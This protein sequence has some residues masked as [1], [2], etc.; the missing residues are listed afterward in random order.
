MTLYTKNLKGTGGKKRRKK[1][2][3]SECSG[4]YHWNVKLEQQVFYL[5]DGNWR[6]VWFSFCPCWCAIHIFT[7]RPHTNHRVPVKRYLAIGW[8]GLNGRYPLRSCPQSTFSLEMLY[9][10]PFHHFLGSLGLFPYPWSD[11]QY[12]TKIILLTTNSIALI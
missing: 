6:K 11:A 7:D 5:K 8:R 12:R 9:L 10:L 3:T 1:N 2:A 4:T